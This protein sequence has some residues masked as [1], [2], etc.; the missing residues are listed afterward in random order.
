MV[1]STSVF[2]E[3]KKIGEVA[4]LVAD[5]W[6]YPLEEEPRRVYIVTWAN[7]LIFS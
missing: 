3:K 6:L 4:S 1:R 2:V 5:A 7:D